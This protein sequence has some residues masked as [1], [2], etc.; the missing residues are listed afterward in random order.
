MHGT[1]YFCI[2]ASAFSLFC[3]ML[4]ALLGRG[5]AETL[6]D[7]VRNLA[8]EGIGWGILAMVTILV[9]NVVL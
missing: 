4:A 5:P 2:A 6:E 8:L 9:Y 7:R 1:T 3:A